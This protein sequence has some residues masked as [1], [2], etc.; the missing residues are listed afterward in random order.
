MG[1]DFESIVGKEEVKFRA[2]IAADHRHH[3]PAPIEDRAFV[4]ADGGVD[5][6]FR[7]WPRIEEGTKV[8]G[9]TIRRENCLSRAFQKLW[10]RQLS[11]E[12]EY[13]HSYPWPGSDTLVHPREPCKVV[14]GK[15]GTGAFSHA[16]N[17]DDISV[18]KR[19]SPWAQPGG[20]LIADRHTYARI[21]S[22]FTMD[23]GVLGPLYAVSGEGSCLDTS[24]GCYLLLCIVYLILDPRRDLGLRQQLGE[25]ASEM[26][27]AATTSSKGIQL[28]DRVRTDPTTGMRVGLNAGRHSHVSAVTLA[29]LGAHCSPKAEDGSGR[30]PLS[31][32]MGILGS[33]TE[34]T[35]AV[36]IWRDII[37]CSLPSSPR[38]VSSAS[39]HFLP[40]FSAE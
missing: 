8:C 13:C 33:S 6:S 29:S 17:G 40:L 21:T 19:G 2:G 10:P 3:G 12:W 22:G 5:E 35:L 9:H 20:L 14:C 30:R 34:S 27:E 31:A 38:L 26:H 28:N 16:C 15:C 7:V 23:K 1:W 25:R 32:Q 11:V 37:S 18:G 36:E 4:G 24:T 39:P